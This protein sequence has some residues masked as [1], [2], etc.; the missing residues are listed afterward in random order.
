[1]SRGLAPAG[2]LWWLPYESLS[3]AHL[4]QPFQLRLYQLHVYWTLTECHVQPQCYW[5][6]FVIWEIAGNKAQKAHAAT[7]VSYRF[8]LDGAIEAE[9]PCV[10]S[11]MWP[12]CRDCA[13]VLV[14]QSRRTKERAT[15][16]LSLHARSLLLSVVKIGEDF[17][18]RSHWLSLCWADLC[19]RGGRVGSNLCC[20]MSKSVASSVCSGE[21][22]AT[23]PVHN[24][25]LGERGGKK[26]HVCGCVCWCCLYF[27]LLNPLSLVVTS[28][29]K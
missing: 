18:L 20:D 16:C 15:L 29:R 27:I 4:R 6:G 28:C 22:T 25:Y 2:D 14:S 10:I 23:G 8:R 24:I 17:T 1:M 5:K 19:W 7:Y 9:R 3:Q 11:W 12:L 26:R 21:V 13:C